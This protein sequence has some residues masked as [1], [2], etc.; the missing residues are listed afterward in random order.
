M[1]ELIERFSKENAVIQFMIKEKFYVSKR[2]DAKIDFGK[3]KGFTVEQVSK[4]YNGLSYLSWMCK[5]PNLNS[6]TK[7]AIELL[8]IADFVKTKSIEKKKVLKSL[9]E[10]LANKIESYR[11]QDIKKGKLKFDEDRQ[12]WSHDI[13]DFQQLI[14]KLKK[15]ICH[16]CE[17][18][19]IINSDI[20]YD[21]RG[22][23][24]DRLNNDMPHTDENTV[25]CC[26]RC[27]IARGADHTPEQFKKIRNSVRSVNQS[28][29]IDPQ[30]EEALMNDILELELNGTA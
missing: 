23:T 16:Y 30:I 10:H 29:P 21:S 4:K 27:N 5:L 2:R 18:E 24:L 19:V 14:H 15:P 3:F 12:M 25:V 26:Y 28:P 9:D 13:I 8:D 1:N 17:I 20:C 22:F 11:Q 6:E 7:Q